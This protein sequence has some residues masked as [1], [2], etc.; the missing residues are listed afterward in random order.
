MVGYAALLGSPF[1]ERPSLLLLAAWFGAVGT[2]A[3]E[4]WGHRRYQL[5]RAARDALLVFGAGGGGALLVALWQRV[6]G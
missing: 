1:G 2:F 6:A 5:R 3:A 4:R